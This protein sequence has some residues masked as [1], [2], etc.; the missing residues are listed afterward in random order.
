MILDPKIPAKIA[1]LEATYDKL[2]YASVETLAMEIAETREHYRSL[3]EGLTWRPVQMGDSWGED[4]NTAWFRG[5]AT[6][7]AS[8]DGETVSAIRHAGSPAEAL[9]TLFAAPAFQWRT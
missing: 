3:P 6:V 8:L 2:R 4:W 9:A 5:T 1:Q 7:P